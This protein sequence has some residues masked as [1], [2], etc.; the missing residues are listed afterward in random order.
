ME[1]YRKI[2]F[3]SKNLN[4]LSLDIKKVSVLNARN[5]NKIPNIPD[6]I[7]QDNCNNLTFH[8]NKLIISKYNFLETRNLKNDINQIRS[9]SLN[10]SHVKLK[11][12]FSNTREI[13]NIL[14]NNKEK[15]IEFIIKSSKIKFFL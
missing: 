5:N 14:T 6:K 7:K 10:Y 3:K 8:I 15:Q 12:K 13:Q 1:E 2:K 4:S 11:K 9:S